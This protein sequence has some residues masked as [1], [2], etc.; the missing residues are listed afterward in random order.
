MSIYIKMVPGQR[1][2]IFP[3]SMLA[4]KPLGTVVVLQSESVGWV[5]SESWSPGLQICMMYTWFLVWSQSVLQG[6]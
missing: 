3:S 6:P 5:T 2:I 1:F 4:Q